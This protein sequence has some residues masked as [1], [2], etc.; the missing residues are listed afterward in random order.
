MS[1]SVLKKEFQQRDIERMRNLMKG[2]HGDKTVVGIGYTKQEEFHKEGDVW[3]E[4]G[5]KWTIKNGIK[6]NLTKL[7]KA[8]QELH[9]PLFCLH[10]NNLMKPHLDK[11]FWIMYKRC[12]N[13]QVDFEAEIRKQGLWEEYEKNIINSD[14]DSTIKEFMIWSDEYINETDSFVTETG[15]VE[16]WIG[17]G[18]EVLQQNVEE[19]IKYLQSLKK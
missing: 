17:K 11:R 14:I 16:K 12:F 2:K 6:Q 19:T 18:K 3:E 4:D 1:E 5:R 10:C 8:K 15:E 13:C 7:D 9:L